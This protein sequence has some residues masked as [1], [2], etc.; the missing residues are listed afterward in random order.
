M[1][2]DPTAR[3]SADYTEARERFRAATADGPH[4]ALE[5]LP[6]FTIDWAWRGDPAAADVLLFTSGLHGIEGFAGGAVQLELLD[7]LGDTPTLLVHALNPW[8]FANYRRVN[9]HNVDL[10]RN[11]LPPGEPYT[12]ADPTFQLADRLLNPPTPPGLD[13]FWFG[14]AW[15]VARHGY[16]A[17]KNAIVGGQYVNPKGLFYGGDRLQPGPSL[18]LPFLDGQLSAKRRVVHVDLHTAL[19]P[20][21][22]RTL[23]LEGQAPPAQLARARA[24]FGEGVK[25]W[26][27]SNKDAYI[28]RGGLCAEL[29][30][31]WPSVRYDGL[32]C[33]FGT[34]SN[35][36]VLQA[37]REENRLHHWGRGDSPAGDDRPLLPH[38]AKEGMRAAFAPRD[39]EWQAAVVGH[40]AP[41]LDAARALLSLD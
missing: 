30:R 41:L 29:A 5:V 16:Q 17:L 23:L 34:R 31:R 32:T 25:G 4:G 6:G 33:E 14:A 36:P 21:G 26:D 20:R 39:A 3:F 19:G 7:R 22:G 35:L 37:L 38:P 18:L 9:E 10:N 12:F 11:F 27:A 24:T 15:L 13:A 40:A 8:G 2:T 1:P 28:I